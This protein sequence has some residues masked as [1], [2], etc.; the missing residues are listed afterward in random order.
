MGA[1]KYDRRLGIKTVGMREWKGHAHYNRYEAT[2]YEALERLF[3]SYRFQKGDR[4]VDFGCGRGRVAF[5]IHHRFRVPVVGIEAHDKTYEE[6]LA[7]KRSYRLKAKHIEAPIKLKY[8]LAEHYQV[9][10]EDNRFY[11][12]NPFSHRVFQRVVR[13]IVHSVEESPRTVEVILYY[14]LPEYKEVLR[15]HSFE[16]INKIQV[17]EAED[18]LEKFLIYRLS[19]P[20]NG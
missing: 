9:K 14:P 13:N 4:V 18:A 11:F 5:A 16:L 19:P 20:E 10:P 15:N 3:E 6:A 12:F 8:G 17:P 1:R 2:P 7:N